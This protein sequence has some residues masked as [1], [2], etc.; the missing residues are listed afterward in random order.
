MNWC[1]GCGENNSNSSS[2]SK[3]KGKCI[4]SC[5]CSNRNC[6]SI[7]NGNLNTNSIKCCYDSSGN[8]SIYLVVLK[9]MVP[10]VA[11]MISGGVFLTANEL[12]CVIVIFVVVILISVM[13]F[14][15]G[16]MSVVVNGK[17]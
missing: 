16:G 15:S 13:T 10:P 2:S 14:N 1:C 5:D 17:W 3:N 11:I 8:W 7:C 12:V 9:D 6:N 4:G